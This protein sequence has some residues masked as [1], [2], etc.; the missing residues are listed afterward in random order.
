MQVSLPK[1]FIK[2]SNDTNKFIIIIIL[3][4]QKKTNY[5]EFNLIKNINNRFEI[6]DSTAKEK[7]HLSGKYGHVSAITDCSCG[8][9]KINKKKNNI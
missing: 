9:K 6:T 1:S 3:L 7:Q 4:V 8:E 5:K 2:K